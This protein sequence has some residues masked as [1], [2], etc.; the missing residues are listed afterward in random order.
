MNLEISLLV[1]EQKKDKRIVLL[2]TD[3]QSWQ[4]L[5]SGQRAFG[6][7]GAGSGTPAFVAAL[8][9]DRVPSVFLVRDRLLAVID[10]V[11]QENDVL[12][13]QTLHS[14]TF[15]YRLLPVAV[16]SPTEKGSSTSMPV[17][18]AVGDRLV[19]ILALPE[20]ERLLRREPVR[21]G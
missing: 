1:R 10:L 20:L 14:V 2:M 12:A 4:M 9:G 16:L 15:D 18:L 19:A 21:G 7:V 3:P 6:G 5:R 13:G 11:I 17:R 8:Y